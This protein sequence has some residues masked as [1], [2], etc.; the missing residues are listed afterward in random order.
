VLEE[1]DPNQINDPHA[2][3]RTQKVLNLLEKTF[4][5]LDKLREENQKLRDELALLKGEQPKPIILPSANS[6]KNQNRKKELNSKLSSEKE[7]RSNTPR[8]RNKRKAKHHKLVIHQQH[9]LSLDRNKLPPDAEFKGYCT[10][11]S[12]IKNEII[13][14]SKR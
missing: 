8:S 13:A 6:S 7:R 3:Q 2:R 14:V 11:Q 10:V 4:V 1:Y 5:Q 9:K 12:V